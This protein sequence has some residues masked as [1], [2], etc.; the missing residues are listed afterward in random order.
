MSIRRLRLTRLVQKASLLICLSVAIYF[1]GLCLNVIVGTSSQLYT[2]N[3]IKQPATEWDL[4]RQ[5]SSTARRNLIIV[6][7]GRSGSTLMGDIFNRHPSVFY[8]YEPLQTVDRVQK[9]MIGNLSYNGHTEKFL[10]SVFRCTFDEP[11]ILQDIEQ[12]YRKPDHPRV[13][14]AIA[15]PPLCP[16]KPTDPRWDQ[17]LC[18]PMTSESLGSACEKNYDLTVIKVLL[19]RVPDNSIKTILTACNPID[20]DC[21]VLFLIRDPRAVITSSRSVGFFQ[22][23][24]DLFARRSTRH[25]S[26]WRCKET[27]D[28]LE[29]IRKLPDSIRERIKLQRYEDLA[30]NPLRELSGLYEFTGLPVLDSVR[31]WLNETT[32]QSRDACNHRLDGEPATCTKDDAWA[33][34][35]RWRWKVH[36]QDINVIEHYCGRVMRL[37]GYRSVDGSYELL[38]NKS[39]ALFSDKYEAK[40]W[41]LKR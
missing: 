24:G 7:H 36:P 2:C 35:N 21:K 26:Y 15:S 34:A 30:I 20:I 12:F 22:E 14:Q 4:N 31:T 10:T 28:N 38:A 32:Q 37:M 1:I 41:F 11:W 33:A 25:F 19:P 29:I 3:Y 27:E 18:P 5:Y 17:L 9:K 8:M 16:Y 6:S 13:S 39:I 40:S 23:R